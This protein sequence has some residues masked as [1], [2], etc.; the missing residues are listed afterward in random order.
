MRFAYLISI[1]LTCNKNYNRMFEFCKRY[2]D[3]SFNLVNFVHYLR[4]NFIRNAS[5]SVYKQRPANNFT[6]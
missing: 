1:Y 5:L 6:N 3:S 4:R 2:S